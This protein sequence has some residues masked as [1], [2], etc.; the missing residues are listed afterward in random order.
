M[1]VCPFLL[2][3]YVVTSNSLVSLAVKHETLPTEHTQQ[4]GSTSLVM[5]H[6]QRHHLTESRPFKHQFHPNT[7]QKYCSLPLRETLRL[8]HEE[9]ISA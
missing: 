7:V 1:Q 3:A 9:I 8:L 5:R 6:A 2:T 4:D